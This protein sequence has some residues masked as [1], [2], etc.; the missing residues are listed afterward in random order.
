MTV[1]KPSNWQEIQAEVQRRIYEREWPPGRIIPGEVDLAEEF[2]VARATVNRALREL[3]ETG[4]LERRRKAGTRVAL[5]PVSKATLEIPV[6]RQEIESR[7]MEY[8]YRRLSID[9]GGHEASAEVPI[10]GQVLHIRALH[11]ADGAP[12]VHEER[13]ISLETVPKAAKLGFEEVSANEWLLANAPYTRG[14]IEITAGASEGHVAEALEAAAGTPLLVI[15]RV[16]WD[17]DA[18]VTCVRLTYAAGHKLTTQ[19]GG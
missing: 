18:P 19:L 2:G 7:G 10:A 8:G 4:L 11:I 6:I 12:Y 9:K 1:A 5:H 3:A 17:H 16:T 14:D 15:R 13:W